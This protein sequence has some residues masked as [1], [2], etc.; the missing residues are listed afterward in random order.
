[1]PVESSVAAPDGEVKSHCVCGDPQSL[2]DYRFLVIWAAWLR[3][4]VVND[5]Q[6]V[7]TGK[8]VNRQR[9][10]GRFDVLDLI[11][12][13]LGIVITIKLREAGGNENPESR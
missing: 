10:T 5:L 9:V 3:L 6:D 12:M 7:D 11:L 2:N 13:H 4:W 8:G 1:M